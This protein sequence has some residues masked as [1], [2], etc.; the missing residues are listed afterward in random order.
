MEN[1]FITVLTF[2]NPQNLLMAR[3]MLESHGIEC[4]TQD[5]LT[6]QAAPFY[7]NAIGGIKL[8]VHERDFQKAVR[9]LVERGYIKQEDLQE[10]KPI[11]DIDFFTSKFPLFKKRS[12][13][14]FVFSA[15][16]FLIGTIGT[17]VYFKSLP[18]AF[19]RLTKDDWCVGDVTYN[20]KNYIPQTKSGLKIVI[21]GVCEE[22]ISFNVNGTLSMPGFNSKMAM[23]KWK[24]ENDL[25][26]ISEVDTFGYI[27]NGWY[28]INFDKKFLHLKSSTTTLDCYV[29]DFF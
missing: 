10:Q 26:Q 8:Q 2:S 14:V 11:F 17:I 7:I 29:M 12:F 22:S 28:E 4:N 3:L 15:I 27:Y 6:A 24:L 23:G 21:Y 16:I 13:R 5:E 1:K 25:L 19:E 18:S 9:L 20:G